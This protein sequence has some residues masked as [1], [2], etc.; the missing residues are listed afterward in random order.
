M[1]G[2][3]GIVSPFE[4]N[5]A[6]DLLNRVLSKQIY[7]GPEGVFFRRLSSAYFA[8]CQLSYVEESLNSQPFIDNTNNLLIVFNGEIYNYKSLAKQICRVKHTNEPLSEA[9]I[10]ASLYK[11]YGLDFVSKLDGMFAIAIYDKKLNSTIL[12][13]DRFGK[14]PLFYC[15]HDEQLI[16]SSELRSLCQFPLARKEL[17]QSAIIKY[18]LF[19]AITSP[20]TIYNNIF[21]VKPGTLLV[22]NSGG[23]KEVKYW[24]PSF[25]EERIVSSENKLLDSFNHYLEQAVVKR[26]SD[27][28]GILMS[29]GV[30]S[31]LLAAIASRYQNNLQTFSITFDEPSYDESYY[32][33]EIAK[34]LNFEHNILKISNAELAGHAIEMLNILDEPVA[35]PSL[36]ATYAICKFA[37][38]KVKGVITGDG[39]DELGMGYRIFYA[40]KLF[41]D[42]NKF[43]LNKLVGKVLLLLSK[44]RNKE[45]NL[46]FSYIANLLKR[47]FI[48]AP[49]YKFYSITSA[50]N[51]NDM[52]STL[53]KSL[54]RFIDTK[55]I[56]YEIDALCKGLDGLEN[57]QMSMITHFLRDVILTK[58]DRGSMM[59]SVEARC[60]FLDKDVS[61]FLLSLPLK[62]K[63][64]GY[65]TKY[66]IKKATEEYLPN[67]LIYRTKMG[68]R[69]P[70]AQL[71]RNE[72]KEFLADSL[73]SSNLIKLHIVQKSAIDTLLKEHFSHK[74][75]NQKQLWSL[76]CLESWIKNNYEK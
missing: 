15:C 58:L 73:I 45:K 13:R 46:H 37:R 4:L 68:F 49:Q 17:N 53:D 55:T 22:I 59:A 14:K 61:N 52:Y 64:N 30:D 75:D 26:L 41:Q 74:R 20:D 47:G 67:H 71:L 5:N 43:L 51:L 2:I 21:K 28:I 6:E 36:I 32:A 31:S 57:L 66:L 18:F 25:S 9:E 54:L 70:M 29:G 62:V 65:R 23:I 42:L 60:P 39:A 27:N 7:R 76:L 33:L 48:E 63:M 8:F 1:C 44:F 56:Y 16:F 40:E 34:H 10:I 38:H 24:K 72:L 50:F 35:D 12:V 11:N 69:L 3:A 19:N